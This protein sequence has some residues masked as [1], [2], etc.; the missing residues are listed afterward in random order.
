MNVAAGLY[1]ADPHE[2]GPGKV[3]LIDAENL[4]RTLCGKWLRA[5]PGKTTTSGRGTCKIC[6]NAV[7][8]R[9]RNKRMDAERRAESERLERARVAQNREWWDW[10]NAY[11]RSPVWRERAAMVRRRAGG[12]C[13]GCGTQPATQVHHL[14]YKHVGREFLWELRAVCEECHDRIHSEERT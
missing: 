10:Y 5:V 12:I 13:E 1:Q 6:L 7:E 4:E 11:L 9:E 8:N 14:T 3:H 2:F